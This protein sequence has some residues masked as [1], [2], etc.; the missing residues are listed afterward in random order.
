[1]EER[2]SV[3][4]L[5]TKNLSEEYVME[6]IMKSKEEAKKLIDENEEFVVVT[7]TGREFNII[8]GVTNTIMVAMNNAVSDCL[9]IAKIVKNGGDDVEG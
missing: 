7:A 3:R 6:E 4:K 1:M 2:D 9:R 5:D 8:G